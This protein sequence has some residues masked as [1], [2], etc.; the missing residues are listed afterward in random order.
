MTFSEH[1]RAYQPRCRQQLL[2]LRTLVQSRD[3]TDLSQEIVEE[4]RD[5]TNAV[6]A[7]AEGLTRAVIQADGSRGPQAETFLWARVTR[8]ATAADRAVSSARNRD[9]RALRAHLHHF[10]T[11]TSAIWTVQ[12]ASYGHAVPD[13]PAGRAAQGPAGL[14]SGVRRTPA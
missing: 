9:V 8:L 11:L 5:A 14:T 2:R 1:I 4:V 7:E 12:Q 3:E 13:Q 10:D 6:I